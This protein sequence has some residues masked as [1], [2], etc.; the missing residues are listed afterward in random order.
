MELYEVLAG[1]VDAWRGSG[2]PHDPYPVI[3]EVLRWAADPEGPGFRLRP[4][5]VRALETYWYLRLVQETPHI[6]ELYRKLFPQTSELLA[7][8]GRTAEE[9]RTY[10]LDHGLDA[11]LDRVRQDDE[12][13]RASRLEALRETLTDL[14]QLHLGAGYGRRQDNPDRRH[15][16][17]RVRHGA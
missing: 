14:P 16:R 7:A 13:A 15:L 9:V 17:H 3:E 11:L 10:V 5:Q 2:Y 4:P 1:E 6:L 12:F 8:L